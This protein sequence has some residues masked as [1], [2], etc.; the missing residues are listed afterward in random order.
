MTCQTMFAVMPEQW[1]NTVDTSWLC[2]VVEAAF[3]RPASYVFIVD[4]Q[5][6]TRS[7]KSVSV[8]K[9]MV[10]ISTALFPMNSQVQ[11]VF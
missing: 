10:S 2:S 3:C 8:G 4:L 5:A 1:C 9:G 7:G 11:Q 6:S